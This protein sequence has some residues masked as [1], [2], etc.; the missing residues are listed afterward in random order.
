MRMMCERLSPSVQN[1][2]KTD[3]RTQPFGVS[4]HFQ[5][6]SRRAAEQQVV[7]QQLVLQH[8]LGKLMGNGEDDVEVRDRNQFAST[9][10]YPA[11]AL[12]RLT[13]RA[14]AVAAGVEGEAE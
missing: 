5:Q 11:V 4:R 3:F 6:R 10:R 12:R 9:R 2:E 8:Q 14:V 7:Q 13:L 1:R